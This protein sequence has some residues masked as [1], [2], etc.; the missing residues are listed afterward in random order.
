MEAMFREHK[1]VTYKHVKNNAIL[2]KAPKIVRISVL[3]PYATDDDDDGDE[4]EDEDEHPRVKKKIVNEIRIVENKPDSS[5]LIGNN[6]SCVHDPSVP[7]K[8]Q[9]HKGGTFTTK[10]EEGI[11]KKYRGVRQRPWGRWAAEIRDPSKKSRVWLGTY[12]TAEE[13]AMVYDRAAIHFKGSK[14]LTNFIKPPPPENKCMFSSEQGLNVDGVDQFGYGQEEEFEAS[15]CDNDHSSKDS[16]QIPSPTSVLRTLE[17]D[18]L[19]WEVSDGVIKVEPSME[20]SFLCLDSE[21]IDCCL[22]FET[23]LPMVLHETSPTQ[24]IFNENFSDISCCLKEDFES[25][26]WDIDS[27]FKCPS[28]EVCK[29]G[30]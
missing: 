18:E 12:D 25:C 28:P 6:V 26:I 2:N 13:A 9:V 24:C 16:H 4:D 20:D 10:A 22:N 8:Q 23:P 5:F 21:S 27:Y 30:E 17:S 14:A 7:L 11:G 29:D 19:K 3:D 15:Y 1:V